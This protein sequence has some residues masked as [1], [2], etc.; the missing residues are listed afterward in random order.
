MK[1][2]VYGFCVKTEKG[3]WWRWSD[4]SI[5]LGTKY[6]HRA[7]LTQIE[8]LKHDCKHL[9]TIIYIDDINVEVTECRDCGAKGR[10]RFEVGE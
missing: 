6:T 1:N 5:H 3:E 8:E 2:T 9:R 4:S 7:T 10:M